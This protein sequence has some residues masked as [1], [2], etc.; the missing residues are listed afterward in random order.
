MLPDDYSLGLATDADIEA[1][2]EHLARETRDNGDGGLFFSPYDPDEPPRPLTPE[3]RDATASAFA[4]ALTEPLWQRTWVLRHRASGSRVLGSLSLYGGRLPSE[5]HRASLGM[6]IEPEHRERRCGS[7]MVEHA[8]RWAREQSPL[9]WI[10]L[11]VFSM[12][13]RARALYKRVGFV[14]VSERRDAF[15]V[16]GVSITDISMTLSL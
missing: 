13:A 1:L 5:L 6:G 15:R 4:R 10:D 2:H 12:N 3:R 16:R 11:G 8:V 9:R 7:A 14:E